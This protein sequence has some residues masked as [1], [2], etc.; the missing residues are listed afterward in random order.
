[1]FL[2]LFVFQLEL[3]IIVSGFYVEKFSSQAELFTIVKLIVKS[4]Y[5]V[6]YD[7]KL[8]NVKMYIAL[9]IFAKT[10]KFID[11]RSIKYRIWFANNN[12]FYQIYYSTVI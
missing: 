9:T 12:L 6:K 10:T 7:A 2:I 8:Y 5:N 1:M 11:S 4:I 3:I